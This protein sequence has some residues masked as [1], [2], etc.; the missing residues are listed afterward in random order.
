VGGSATAVDKVEV[1]NGVWQTPVFGING[2]R[3]A[4]SYKGIV[5]GNRRKC[6]VK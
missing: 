3:V 2:Q 1:G 4:R 6:I 5:V